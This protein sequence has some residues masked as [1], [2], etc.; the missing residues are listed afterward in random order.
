MKNIEDSLNEKGIQLPS[1]Y[2]LPIRYDYEPEVDYPTD[3]GADGLQSY[4]ET[5][6]SLQ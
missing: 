6:G 2:D 5:I 3:L 1:K 4:Q